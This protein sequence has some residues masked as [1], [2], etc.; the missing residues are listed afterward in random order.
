DELILAR[1]LEASGRT[2]SYVQGRLVP[3]SVLAEVGELLIEICGQHESH[4]LRSPAAQLAALDRFAGLEDEVEAFSC[5]HDELK[6]LEARFHEAKNQQMA[7]E[8]RRELIE[9]QL[10]ELS[11]CALD[12]YAEGR[13]R[14]ELAQ[15]AA[16]L[17]GLAGEVRGVLE[18]G[19]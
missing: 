19:D 6:T 15:A 10:S 2:R 7:L 1:R 14:I 11:E 13:R 5:A 9:L 4:A 16:E 12:E 8:T 17:E 3:R 18:D